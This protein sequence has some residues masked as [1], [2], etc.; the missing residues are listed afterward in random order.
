MMVGAS[1]ES[2]EKE[3]YMDRP[4]FACR[5]RTMSRALPKRNLYRSMPDEEESRTMR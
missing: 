5:L 4:F 3:D 1:D 2:D